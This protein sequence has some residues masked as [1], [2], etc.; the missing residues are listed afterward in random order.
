MPMNS[1]RSAAPSLQN[2]VSRRWD[3]VANADA[4]KAAI[5]QQ[6]LKQPF[7]EIRLIYG[8]CLQQPGHKDGVH[9]PAQTPNRETKKAHAYVLEAT[10][11]YRQEGLLWPS[12]HR[13]PSAT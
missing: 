12:A 4:D 8:S 9:N 3:R 11:L 2:N 5:W 7:L 13:K 10:V 6:Y 1:S